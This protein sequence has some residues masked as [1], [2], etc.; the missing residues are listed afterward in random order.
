MDAEIALEIGIAGGGWRRDS[1][2]SSCASDH[3]TE[4]RVLE[5]RKN[6]DH[7]EFVIGSHRRHLHIVVAALA[8]RVTVRMKLLAR[9][10]KREITNRGASTNC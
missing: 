8:E 10:A 6:R 1:I 9:A 5:Q 7:F 2:P 3:H 4:Y